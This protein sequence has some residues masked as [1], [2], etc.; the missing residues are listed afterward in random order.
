MQLNCQRADRMKRTENYSTPNL[1]DIFP[2]QCPLSFFTP[3]LFSVPCFPSLFFSLFLLPSMYLSPSFLWFTQA[4][5]RAAGR[6]RK[7]V[8][9]E[10]SSGGRNHEKRRQRVCVCVV[11]ESEEEKTRWRGVR[12]ANEKTEE[13]DQMFR[14]PSVLESPSK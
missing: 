2:N 11:R 6:G 14:P 12:E 9:G 4:Q 13:G 8:E 3:L 1:H 7:D 5:R 10:T